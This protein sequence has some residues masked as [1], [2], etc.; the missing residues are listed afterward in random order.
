MSN[1]FEFWYNKCENNYTKNIEE[2]E[3]KIKYFIIEIII[4][5]LVMIYGVLSNS[6]FIFW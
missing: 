1:S 6:D 5:F 2:A 4:R 3:G